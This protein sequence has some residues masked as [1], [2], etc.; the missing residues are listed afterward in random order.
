MASPGSTLETPCSY[1]G[2]SFLKFIPR[3]LKH[4]SWTVDRRRHHAAWEIHLDLLWNQTSRQGDLGAAQKWIHNIRFCQRSALLGERFALF[5]F[6]F[7]LVPALLELW[8]RRFGQFLAFDFL[9]ILD[10]RVEFSLAR[11]FDCVL[12]RSETGFL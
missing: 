8:N 5:I 4:I 6:Q 11:R 7:G 12:V 3:R 9:P 10:F 2:I 1:A